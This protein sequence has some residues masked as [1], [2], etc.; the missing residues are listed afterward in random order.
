MKKLFLLLLAIVN[1]FV[2]SVKSSAADAEKS[3]VPQWY[4]SL[5]A[6]LKEAAKTKRQILLVV[7]GSDWCPPCMQL[8]RKIFSHKDFLKIAGENL[9]LLKAD[10]PRRKPQS[11]QEKADA[12]A[13]VKRYPIEAYPTVFLLS[14][15]GEVLDKKVGFSNSTPEKY[16]ESFK[17]FKKK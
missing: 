6:A 3:T 2:L 14:S 10:F 5:D 7:S 4:T 16:L 15:T 8:E 1:L 9:V 17:G 11:R 12:F 13:I